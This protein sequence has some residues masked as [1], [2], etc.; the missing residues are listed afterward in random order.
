MKKES[1]EENIYCS[2]NQD[3]MVKVSKVV[4]IMLLLMRCF[5]IS[6]YWPQYMM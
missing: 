4:R 5:V 6:L 2:I 1:R 3:D